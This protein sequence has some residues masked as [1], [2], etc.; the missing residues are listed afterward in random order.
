MEF[1][2]KVYRKNIHGILSL[3]V[4]LNWILAIVNHRFYCQ[5][6]FVILILMQ[7]IKPL[8]FF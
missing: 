2:K 8:I 5:K 7:Q 3:Q 4:Y 1:K 6:L